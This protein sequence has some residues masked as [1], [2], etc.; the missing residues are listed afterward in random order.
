MRLRGRR[1]KDSLLNDDASW[2]ADPA[3]QDAATVRTLAQV[4]A[5]TA[6]VKPWRLPAAWWRSGAGG[7]ASSPVRT[8][9][10]RR[11]HGASAYE[12]AALPNR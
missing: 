3:G 7:A 11:R 5:C 1:H 12:W 4:V 8:L 2:L 6:R 10:E 9:T